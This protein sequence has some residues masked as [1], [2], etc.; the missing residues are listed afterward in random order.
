MIDAT[1]TLEQVEEQ[2]SK[3][4]S[5]ASRAATETRAIVRFL[6]AER[7]LD[8]GGTPPS[9]LEMY[10]PRPMRRV[11][12]GPTA[13]TNPAGLPDHS[14]EFEPIDEILQPH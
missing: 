2:L 6:L 5:V 10:P 8:L 14:A 13:A 9:L 4:E 7:I 1:W 3:F 11:P 12:S